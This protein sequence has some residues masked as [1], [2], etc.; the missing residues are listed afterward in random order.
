MKYFKHYS[1]VRNSESIANLLEELG[2]EGYARYWILLELLAELYDGTSTKFKI[3]KRTLR[4]ALRFRSGLQADSYAVAIG[5][6]P[7]YTVVVTETHYFIDAAILSELQSRDYKKAR[8]DR[9]TTAPKNKNKNKNK[10]ICKTPIKN[11]F[12]DLNLSD[13]AK[14]WTKKIGQRTTKKMIDKYK[15]DFIL[16][17]ILEA[18]EWT[19]DNPDK[20]RPNVGGF[21]SNWFK[22]SKNPDKLIVDPNSRIDAELIEMLT[23]KK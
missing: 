9:A 16:E 22:N 8:S 10:S 12:Q 18:Y 3:H 23:G 14:E 20:K 11:D 4:T 21:L 15:P 5:L 13:A 17:E 19:L 6:Q 7:G 2:L 1:D